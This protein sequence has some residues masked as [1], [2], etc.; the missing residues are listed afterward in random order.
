MALKD[1]ITLTQVTEM[2]DI[3]KRTLF[4]LEESGKLHFSRVK[5]K[6]YVRQSEIERVLM[7]SCRGCK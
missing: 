2:I 1:W 5:G 4:R 7:D 6:I 3:S